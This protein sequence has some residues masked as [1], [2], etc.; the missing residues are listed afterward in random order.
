MHNIKVKD[1]MAHYI[2]IID[3]NE[4]LQ[5]AASKMQIIDCGALPVGKGNKLEGI[6]TDRDIVIRA[7]SKGKNPAKEQ[8]KDYMTATVDYCRDTDTLQKAADQMHKYQVSRLIVKDSDGNV[9]GIIS[10]G[11][12]LRKATRASDITNIIAHATGTKVA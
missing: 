2:A 4:S 1:I 11:H 8:V 3:P 12:I 6:I 9:S 7:V 10:L 5:E